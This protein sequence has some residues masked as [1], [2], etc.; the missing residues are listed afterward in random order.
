MSLKPAC[1]AARMCAP[2]FRK[3]PPHVH[4]VINMAAEACPVLPKVHP[5]RNLQTMG[6]S[7]WAKFEK[8]CPF[9]KIVQK[10]Y[11]SSDLPSKQ[12]VTPAAGPLRMYA[13]R[14]EDEL[15]TPAPVVEEVAKPATKP[16]KAN[17]S[18][19]V[20]KVV[21]R[22]DYDGFFEESIEK[23]KKEGRYREFKTMTRK[24]GQ[25]PVCAQQAS[26]FGA[27]SPATDS[28]S[29]ESVDLHSG[30]PD[31]LSP[32]E[33][34]DVTIWC[35]NDYLGMGQHPFVLDAVVK[36][37][38]ESG[39]GSGGTRNIGGTN[40]YHTLLEAEIADLHHKEASLVFSNC[41]SANIALISAVAKLIPNIV[42]LS[43]A[44]NHASLIEGIRGSGAAKRIFKHNDMADLERLLTEIPEGTPK[45]I[46][47]ES[48]YSMDGTIAPIETVCDLADKY[49]AMT[50]I[51]EVH[52]VGLYGKRGGGVCERDGQMHRLDVISGTLGKAFGVFGGYVAASKHIV[53]CVR[54]YAPGLIFSTS[55]PPSVCAGAAASVHYLK[56]HHELRESH[57]AKSARLKELLRAEGIPILESPSHIVPVMIGDAVKCKQMADRLLNHYGIYVQPINYPTVAVGSERFR[58]TPSPVHTE[59]MMIYLKDSLVALWREFNMPLKHEA[60][61]PSRIQF[62][63]LPQSLPRSE[64]VAPL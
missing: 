46:I 14:A 38:M 30:S 19:D 37:V 63:V 56:A 7:M 59:E 58:F 20:T 8:E 31:A 43:D 44:K 15:H 29:Q 61:T 1:Q 36:A 25:F 62:K 45:M 21:C 3:T 32:A 22:G 64:A 28:I 54:S 40:K 52:A 9:A 4:P 57:Q 17:A 33:R 23:L 13:R 24:A 26:T 39:A 48:V 42:F 18:S 51:D 12:I 2:I 49:N 10:N 41:F 34:D 6:T 5:S 53:D 47:F 27:S 11:G 50:F 60:P 35:S 16:V 55:P